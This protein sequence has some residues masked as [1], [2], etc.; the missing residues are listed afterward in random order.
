MNRIVIIT[1]LALCTFTCQA[2]SFCEKLAQLKKECYGFK[3]TLLN[4][5]EKEAK[6]GKLDQ[7]WNLAKTDPDKALPCLKEMITNENNDPYFC[8]DASS[9]ILSLD[10]KEQYLDVVLAGVKKTD[11]RDLQLEN[12][13]QVC[14]FLGR[15]GKDVTLPVEKL[16]SEPHAH[17]YLTVHVIDLSAIDASLF[18]YNTMSTEA[19]ERSLINTIT[20]GNATGK[21]NAAVV[22]NLLSTIRG[23][24]LLNQLIAKNQL[25]DST[26]K[27]ILK[28]REAFIKNTKTQLTAKDEA[29]VREQRQQSITAVSDESL[30]R[31][32][33]LTGVL[34]TIRN[35]H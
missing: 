30:S 10:K 22:L 14:Y 16:I 34:L 7:F 9:L 23:D 2:Q 33:E 32:F 35:K 24:S 18:L 15:K 27:F 1:L 13:L 19:A 4:E 21:H 3:P 29:K 17:V 8:F 28:D 25:A 31:Y 11:L 5:Q 26:R 20:N 12:Y 6:S